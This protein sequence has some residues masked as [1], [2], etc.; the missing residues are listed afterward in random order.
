MQQFET[1]SECAE[2]GMAVSGRSPINK[3]V[4]RAFFNPCGP[5]AELSSVRTNGPIGL[6]REARSKLA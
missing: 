5:M 2:R 3:I 1:T 6:A 4:L